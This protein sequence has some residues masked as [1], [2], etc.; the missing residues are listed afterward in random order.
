VGLAKRSQA[1][2][3]S[4]VTG[5]LQFIRA[6]QAVLVKSYGALEA[7]NQRTQ[8]RLRLRDPHSGGWPAR[9]L[10]ATPVRA[11]GTGAFADLPTMIVAIA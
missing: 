10:A 6:V 5:T 8:S 2:L 1:A 11:L 3:T 9:R 7:A 4:P